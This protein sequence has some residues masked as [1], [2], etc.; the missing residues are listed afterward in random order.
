[1]LIILALGLRLGVPNPVPYHIYHDKY[2]AI[3]LF[4]N[5]DNL[6]RYIEKFIPR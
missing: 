2:S 5:R 3:S 1:M 4:N 6:K